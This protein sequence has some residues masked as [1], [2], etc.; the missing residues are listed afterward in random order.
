[1]EVVNEHINI[2]DFRSFGISFSEIAEISRQDNMLIEIT[3]NDI[4]LRNQEGKRLLLSSLLPWNCSFDVGDDFNYHCYLGM[5]SYVEYPASATEKAYFLISLLHEIGHAH[6][7]TI[8][9]RQESEHNKMRTTVGFSTMFLLDF[10]ENITRRIT[11]LI[12]GKSYISNKN[13]R[14]EKQHERFAWNFALRKYRELKREW[15]DLSGWLTNQQ[16]W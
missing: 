9:K 8:K 13:L 4:I 15:W 11:K 1:M 6:D 16:I 5:K 14:T 3:P 7:E 10:T 12:T 2:D